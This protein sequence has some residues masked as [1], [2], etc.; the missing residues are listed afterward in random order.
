MQEFVEIT[1]ENIRSLA[2]VMDAL[3]EAA[4]V[5]ATDLKI[6]FPRMLND[7]GV[8]WM[9]VRSQLRLNRMPEGSL[10]IQTWLRQTKSAVSNRDFALFD[11]KGE[12]GDAVQSWV[13]VDANTRKL[14]NMK[15]MEPLWSLP[16]PQPEK[17][18][19]PR[20]LSIALMAKAEEFTVSAAE[21]DFNGHFNNV[22]YIRHAEKYAPE[23]AL[24]LDVSY[25]RECFLGETLTLHAEN[26][27]VYIVKPDGS[28]AFRA[29]FYKGEPI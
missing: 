22:H 19:T 2:D 20:R 5:H 21:L 14:V 16:F 26:G 23:G 27:F 4:T 1:R 18:N 6:D 29:H 7:F 12:L 8:L 25:E 28:T 17:T 13:L 11:D 24:C 15:N 10:R 9:I 3:E